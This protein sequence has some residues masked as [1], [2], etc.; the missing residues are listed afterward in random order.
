MEKNTHYYVI[1]VGENR[2]IVLPVPASYQGLTVDYRVIH[3]DAPMPF[4]RYGHCLRRQRADRELGLPQHYPCCPPGGTT[5]V[6]VIDHIE[7]YG[8]ASHGAG[9][10]IARNRPM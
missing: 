5:D 9:C 3:E 4:I 8:E 7:A 2:V 10:K 6:V 1:N